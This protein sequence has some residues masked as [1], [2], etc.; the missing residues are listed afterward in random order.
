VAGWKGRAGLI[1]ST[2]ARAKHA[3]TPNTGDASRHVI[4]IIE[5]MVSVLC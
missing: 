4:H 5:G 1:P 2:N 3:Q